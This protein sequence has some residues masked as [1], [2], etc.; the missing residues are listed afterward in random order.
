MDNSSNSEEEYPDAIVPEIRNLLDNSHR[1]RPRTSATGAKQWLRKA[2]HRIVPRTLIPALLLLICLVC[3]WLWPIEKHEAVFAFSVS[4]AA[5]IGCWFF[6]DL[7][8]S[9]RLRKWYRDYLDTT[10]RSVRKSVVGILF[11]SA[12]FTIH[13][14]DPSARDAIL[15]ALVDFTA[16]RD[17]FHDGENGPF[18]RSIRNWDSA[19][20]QDIIFHFNELAYAIEATVN[21]CPWVCK[22]SHNHLR[23]VCFFIRQ[24]QGLSCFQGEKDKYVRDYL[25]LPIMAN[26]SLTEGALSEDPI[27]KAIDQL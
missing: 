13:E 26:W 2:F 21:N 27:Q 18:S 5:G 11:D 12:R 8:P 25:I 10:Y 17:F 20:I 15:D 7:M 1:F 23:H 3:C 6:L 4:C 22:Q 24:V 19:I 16:F 14:Y 9:L